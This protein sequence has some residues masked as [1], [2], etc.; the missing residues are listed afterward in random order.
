MK[1]KKMKTKGHDKTVLKL[2]VNSFLKIN[3]YNIK[4]AR[5]R[6]NKK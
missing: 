4:E 3:K 2:K 5:K 1:G 6:D